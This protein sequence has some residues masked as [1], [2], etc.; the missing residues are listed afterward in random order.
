MTL[1]SPLWLLALLLVPVF[2]LLGHRIKRGDRERMDTLVTASMFERIGRRFPARV[3]TL[4]AVFLFAGAAFLVLALAR[5]QWGI[6]RE[7]VERTGVDVAIV[8]DTSL[9][10]SVED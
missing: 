8:L 3:E 7:R 4:R 6:V 9:S 1:A 10:M 2:A 5:P